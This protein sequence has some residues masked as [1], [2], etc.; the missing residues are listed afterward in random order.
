MRPIHSLWHVY[1][2]ASLIGIGHKPGVSEKGTLGVFFAGV[3]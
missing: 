1:G 2:K 3:Q